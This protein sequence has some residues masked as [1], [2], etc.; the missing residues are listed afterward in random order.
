MLNVKVCVGMY[1]DNDDA[2]CSSC[3]SEEDYR[4]AET[5][6][7]S[8]DEMDYRSYCVKCGEPIDHSLTS[9]G[10]AYESSLREEQEA[11]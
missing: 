8:F 5:I 9:D 4:N 11:Y 10:W 7:S 3:M 1:L 2:V 6:I